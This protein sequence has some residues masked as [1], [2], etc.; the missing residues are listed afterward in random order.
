[1]TGSVTVPPHHLSTVDPSLPP[2]AAPEDLVS[3]F[4]DGTAV[5]VHVYVADAGA[6]QRPGLADRGLVRRVEDRARL[7]AQ[8]VTGDIRP[9]TQ[10]A[11]PDPLAQL[12]RARI[13]PVERQ[14]G[15]GQ[16][17]GV[18]PHLVGLLDRADH[19]EAARPVGVEVLPYGGE[20]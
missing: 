17:L 13:Q 16:R 9:T 18:E 19:H 1:M 8:L 10:P 15:G 3:E 20:V 11:Q 7:P 12:I 2:T 5:G 6:L 4:V 14:S